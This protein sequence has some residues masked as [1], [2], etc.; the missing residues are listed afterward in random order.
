MDINAI[1]SRLNQL[2]N[3]SSTAS[4]IW[5]PQ[6]G[7][8]QIRIVPYAHNKDN[9]FIELFFHYSLV[10]NKT[11]LSPQS[12]GRPDPV[13]QFADKLKSSGDKDEWIQGKRIEPKM[14]TFAPVIV[15]GEESEGV[16]F[17]GFGKTVYQELLGIIADPDYG[18]IS[19]PMTGRD[20]VVERQTPA[21]A[22]NQYGK[23]TIRV[24][25]NQTE[26]VDDA[27][28]QKK[29]LEEQANYAELFTEPTYDELK[30]HL[31][32]FL[33]PSAVEEKKEETV[34]AKEMVST[35]ESSNT[36]VEDDFDKLFNS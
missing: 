29:L 20:I 32:N 6:P 19:D 24:K 2:Q 22:G 1:K 13:Q 35:T 27:K 34:P 33:N 10:P 30:D 8:T 26:L 14:R 11:V 16:K 28:M 7:K 12:F 23:T 15:R 4:L 18:D 17:W 25:P 31:Q 21:E 9:P 3:T 5:K 36:K